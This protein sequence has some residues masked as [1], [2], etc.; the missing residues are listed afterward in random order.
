MISMAKTRRARG[1]EEGPSVKRAQGMYA[2]GAS[3]REIAST[4]GASFGGVRNALLRSG[5]ELRARGGRGMRDHGQQSN[6]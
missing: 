3:I 5:V 4:L 6:G 1:L 2:D